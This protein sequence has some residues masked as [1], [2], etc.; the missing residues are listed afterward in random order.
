MQT[1]NIRWFILPLLLALG[2]SG[3]VTKSA[4]KLKEQNAY[5][6]GQQE[7]SQQI[8]QQQQQPVVFFRGLVRHTRVPWREELTLTQALSEAQFT[9][10]TNPGALR[11]N[12]HGQVFLIDLRR[13]LR[14]QE[15]PLLEPGDIVEVMR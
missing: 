15:D 1:R 6:R 7:A 3:C 5:L 14:G 2:G 12:R 9:G 4:S 10:A 11:L 8:Q 13:F